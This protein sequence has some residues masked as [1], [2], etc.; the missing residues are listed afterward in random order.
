MSGEKRPIRDG[1]SLTRWV[2]AQFGI[3]ILLLAC[4]PVLLLAGVVRSIARREFH[5]PAFASGLAVMLVGVSAVSAAVFVGSPGLYGAR[6]IG[7]WGGV[8]A[9]LMAAGFVTGLVGRRVGFW[10]TFLALLLVAAAVYVHLFKGWHVLLGFGPG[11]TE[12]YLEFYANVQPGL[13]LLGPMWDRMV[14][15][16]GAVGFLLAVFG[17]SIAYLLFSADRRLDVGFDFE[18]F[19]GVRHL[20]GQRVSVTAVVAVL[21]V[22]LGVASL[23]AVTSVMSGYQE[24]IQAKILSTNAHFVVQKYGTDFVEYESVAAEGLEHPMVVA[25]TAFTFNTATLST[26]DRGVG[27]LIKGVIPD[28]AGSVT[29]IEDNLCKT[30]EL[31]GTCKY[32]C[33]TERSDG[34]CAEIDREG[35]PRLPRYLDPEDGVPSLIVGSALF[36]KLGLPVG[37]PVTLTTPVGIAGARGNAPRRLQFRLAGAF[38]SGMHDFDARLIYLGLAA[39]QHLM[40]LGKAVN[41]V[42]FR[43]KDPEVADAVAREVL[44]AVGRYP[45][46]TLGWRELNAGIF[47]ALKLQKILMFLVLTFIIIVA[48]FN[49]ASTLFMAVVEK[50]HEIAVLKSMGSRDGSIMKIFVL[51]GWLVGGIGTLLGVVLGLAV[52][53]IL[54]QLEL[55][56]AA[57]VY[58]VESLKVSV[59]TSEVLLTVAA[60]FVISHLAT[61]YPALSAARSRPVDAMRYE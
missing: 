41:G 32:F 15:L 40:G 12:T 42:E 24:D 10:E 38:R 56:I 58:M 47:T 61:I 33:K 43:I 18:W 48:A 7:L 4:S 59:H 45:Y 1:S 26:G 57:D 3:F 17:G 13:S 14:G 53:A 39:S 35:Q 29:S 16:A 60:A 46:R 52:C 27:V 25:A 23:V 31:D 51:E 6:E 54:G 55:S 2:T 21:G 19:V 28:E 11:D 49:I 30:I 37:S 36:K 22:A 9:V 8:M 44:R 34:S 20:F 5:W 50:A